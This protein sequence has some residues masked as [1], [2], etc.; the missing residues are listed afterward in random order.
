ML[1]MVSVLESKP[2][3]NLDLRKRRRFDI[4]LGLGGGPIEKMS[5]MS[6]AVSRQ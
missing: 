3:E 4:C 5:N 6:T 1:Q 2:Q